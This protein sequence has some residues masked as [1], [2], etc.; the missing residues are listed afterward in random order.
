MITVSGDL[1]V[2]IQEDGVWHTQFTMRQ[3]TIGDAI[4]AIEK[5]GPTS[6][7]LML[8]IYKAAEQI[9]QIHGITEITGE[10]LL[11]LSDEDITPILDAQDD[12][13]KKLKGLRRP[14]SPTST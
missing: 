6:S 11:S 9:E 8:R 7:N 10:L 12:L 14:S 4:S 13:E 3:A 1:I 2:G 5:A